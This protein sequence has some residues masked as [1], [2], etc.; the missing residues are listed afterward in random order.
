MNALAPLL[1]TM[2]GLDVKGKRVLVRADLNVP[3]KDG[4][5]TDTSRIESLC[6]T[7]RDLQREGAR[8]I[9]CSHLG[10]PKGRYAPSLSLAPVART[11]GV[12]LGRPVGFAADCVGAVAGQAVGQLAEGEVLVLENT[13]FHPEEEANDPAFAAELASLADIYV[14]DAFSAAHRA[15]AS[16]EAVAHLLPSC[17][18]RLMQ[19]ELEALGSILDQPAHPFAAVIGGVKI[20]T[21]LALLL[22]LVKDVDALFLG[23]AMANTFLAATGS[24][25]G[26]SLQ[27]PQMHGVVRDIM[28]AARAAGC[29]IILPVDVVVAPRLVE[30]AIPRTVLVGQVPDDCMILDIGP[31]TLADLAGR[32]ANVRTVIWNGPLGAFETPPFDIG[33]RGFAGALAAAT[34]TGRLRSVAGG[35]DTVAALRQAGSLE[36]LSYVSMAGGAFLEWLEGRALPG[37]VAVSNL[38]PDSRQ[39]ET[40]TPGLTSALGVRAVPSSGEPSWTR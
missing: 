20:S 3:M 12:I 7:V 25:I 38:R 10:R 17:A 18:G 35:G 14:N 15:H 31:Q 1:R 24:A 37:V 16:T 9:L 5:V 40:S 21:K 27:E 6:P 22:N 28:A 2:D 13:R 23:G 34:V 33:T 29:E 30:G 39:L 4:V 19:H 26:T 11:L 36:Q 8:T 32:L